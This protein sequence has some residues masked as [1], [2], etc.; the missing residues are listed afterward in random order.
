[1]HGAVADVA[2]KRLCRAMGAALDPLPDD[3]A[4][5]A[6]SNSDSDVEE[7]D[8]IGWFSHLDMDDIAADELTGQ[9]SIDQL[10]KTLED[11]DKGRF[12][13]MTSFHF[14]RKSSIN[15]AKQNK[16]RLCAGGAEKNAS[17]NSTIC[18]CIVCRSSSASASDCL[19]LKA[20]NVR[21]RGG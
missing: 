7:Q 14:K 20:R 4:S 10:Q 8:G 12:F 17:Y 16:T 6:F 2:V 1:M 15:V 21:G 5:E 11:L 13:H 9:V 3:S 18:C 19:L